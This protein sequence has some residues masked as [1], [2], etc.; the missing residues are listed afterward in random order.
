MLGK[1]DLVDI[2]IVAEIESQGRV[3]GIE[4]RMP[5][6]VSGVGQSHLTAM[7]LIEMAGVGHYRIVRQIL[8]EIN[9]KLRAHGEQEI[10]WTI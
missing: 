9:L 2:V 6:L 10:D 3:V 1:H 5:I 7:L 4:S 8:V